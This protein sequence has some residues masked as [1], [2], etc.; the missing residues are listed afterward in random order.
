[1]NLH[2]V[3][4]SASLAAGPNLDT[5]FIQDDVLGSRNSHLILTEDFNAIMTYQIGA[6]MTRA[7]FGNAAL[8]QKG[9]NHL[10]PIEVS[11]TVPRLPLPNDLRDT[12]LKLPRNEEITI[13]SANSGAGP[14][15]TSVILWLASP[16]WSQN[17][18][19]YLD[20]LTT[21]CTVVVAAGAET[22]WGPLG[23]IVM[24]QDLL[25]GVYAV[26]GASFVAAAA[27]AFRFRFPDQPANRGKQYRPGALVQESTATSPFA[28]FRG[29][30]GEWGRFHT[31]TL[32][33]VQFLADAAGGTYEGRLD[34]LYLGESEGLLG[35]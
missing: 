11:A 19:G 21:R 23:T 17:L 12:P 9:R 33:Q 30:M 18:P 14:T 35:V 7:R 24:E 28:G 2:T 27:L 32:P 8:S 10:W 1:M 13:E 6:L 31:F 26:I 20:R 29:G 22:T 34:L 3:A 16:D 4:Y 15:Q 25:N 5:A